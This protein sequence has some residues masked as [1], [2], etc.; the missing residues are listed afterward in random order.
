VPQLG[1][2]ERTT[3]FHFP[4]WNWLT[5][6][7]QRSQTSSR[8]CLPAVEQ[9]EDR[10]V[11]A[12]GVKPAAVVTAPT[13]AAV[14]NFIKWENDFIKIQDSYIKIE[15][16]YLKLYNDVL[17]PDAAAL[18]IKLDADFAA[19]DNDLAG[20]PSATGANGVGGIDGTLIMRRLS[21]AGATAAGDA[22]LRDAAL[23]QVNDGLIQNGQNGG[24]PGATLDFVHIYIK[25]EALSLKLHTAVDDSEAQFLKI[26]K[27]FIAVDPNDLAK[28]VAGL[29]SDLLKLDTDTKPMNSV[30]V[31]AFLKFEEDFIKGENS[32]IKIEGDFLLKY[33]SALP[34]G[35]ANYFIKLDNDYLN[36]N[37]DL[38][39]ID[40]ALIGLL[41]QPPA[42]AVST[43]GAA[44]FPA[45]VNNEI[46]GWIN[47]V[48]PGFNDQL[49]ADI[50]SLT[51]PTTVAV[52]AVVAAPA[53][54]DAFLKLDEIKYKEAVDVL[55]LDLA[56]LKIEQSFLEGDPDRPLIIGFASDLLALTKDALGIPS[57]TNGGGTTTV[58]A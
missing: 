12:V 29:D 45:D 14:N 18:F 16:R 49:N 37:G 19:I 38:V 33:G 51:P 42:T 17:P 47:T 22:V 56:F 9:L 34:P 2:P 46:S 39:K 57:T 53:A 10:I 43:G 40:S 31:D 7:R 25:L 11:P 35:A 4:T 30:A 5:A 27:A 54:V 28:P 13:P 44:N 24:T 3:M 20:S 48:L 52:A 36:A 21:S 6:T 26:E 58:S 8:P 50:I 41:N 55:S 32:F 23:I 15:D 1:M